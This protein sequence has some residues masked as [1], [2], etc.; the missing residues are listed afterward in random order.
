MPQLSLETFV[1]QYFW[2]VVVILGL[3]YINTEIIIPRISKIRK[4][5]EIGELK[6]QTKEREKESPIENA[7]KY[8]RRE[9]L[10]EKREIVWEI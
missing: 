8:K 5:R 10:R 2:L 1:S 9:G 3:Y 6:G 4:A 7:A